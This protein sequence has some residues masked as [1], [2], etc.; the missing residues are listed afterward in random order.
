MNFAL[1]GHLIG[2]RYRLLWASMRR[3]NGRIA[4]FAV[5]YMLLMAIGAT[6]AAG[7]VG[8]GMTA[9]K[10]GRAE[11]LAQGLL[12]GIFMTALV[13]S[14]ML[15]FGLSAVFS[16]AELRRYP[17][18]AAERRFA[19]YFTGMADPFWILFALL[20]TG[21]A[22]G[23]YLFG[24]SNLALGLLAVL[25]LFT[26]N[27]LA[28]QVVCLTVEWV[29]SKK[30]GSI[31]LPILF[32]GLC[33]APSVATPYLRKVSPEIMQTAMHALRA[34]PGFAAGT[35]MA[36][37]DAAALG[38]AGV[39]VAWI[40]ALLAALAAL[41]RLPRKMKTAE[42][43]QISWGSPFDR[44]GAL[45]GPE[46][47]PL[48]THWLQFY[49]RCRRFRLSYIMSLP[50]LPFL[51]LLWTRQGTKDPHQVFGAA[52]GVFA[53]AGLAPAAAFLVN[54]FGYV[55]G[56]FRRYFLFPGDA[57]QALRASSFTLLALCS[58]SLA[59]ATLAWVLFPP[60][61]LT[62]AS[63]TMLVFSGISGLLLFHGTGLWTTVYGPRR[64][65]PNKTMGNDLSLAGNV[66]VVG[67]MMSM[68][69]T[70]RIISLIWRQVRFADYW[71][72]P[73]ALS[74]FAAIYYVYSLKG[75][76]AALLRRREALIST[77]EGKV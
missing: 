42:S 44:A 47:A 37:T 3:R 43:V 19:R 9:V 71:Y 36:R 74:G 30:G 48:V 34:T 18:R 51:L 75:A 45:F 40:A 60:A 16:D 61:P 68:L 54:Q 70:P 28:A 11:F 14:V 2:L 35:M 39:L 13:T 1:I 62:L 22:F 72:A 25:L 33:L 38:G 8:A 77:L 53:I 10:A 23:L 58:L 6:F 57:A 65:D 55:G 17:L 66:V 32:V 49:F 5:G 26:A 31:A 29:M 50:L 63:V 7:G 59:L 46:Y 12:L 20:E 76:S 24:V 56:G 15:G 67:G 4:V 52:V 69:M 41:E 64:A 21:L 73:V 27:Y